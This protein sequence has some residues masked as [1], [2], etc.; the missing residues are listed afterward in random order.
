MPAWLPDTPECRGEL[1]Q[2][3]QAISRLDQGV[4]VL[5]DTLKE[6]GHWNDTL[7]LFLSDNG[8]PFPGAKTNLY[9][10]GSN[11]PLLV[12]DPS[13]PKTGG[14]TNARVTW[15]DVV[16]TILDYC[17]VKPK[18]AP[19]IKTQDNIGK[20]TARGKAVP[21]T[22]HGRSFLQILNKE[23]PKDWNEIY[24]SH[25]FHEITM[26]YP[27]RIIL[28]DQYKLTFNIAHDLPYPFASDLYASPTWQSVLKAKSLL[29]GKRTIYNYLHRPEFEMYDLKNDPDEVL[30]LAYKKEYQAEFKKLSEKLKAWQKETNDPWHLKW[31]Y[32]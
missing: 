20:R 8:P 6:T 19:A 29:Y 3:Y 28:S 22:T 31:E 5:L 15:A 17:E 4:G 21:F 11:L 16:P 7:I 1:A 26:Y 10:P 27:M 32:E 25:T 2:Y 23:N 24:L 9:Q 14:V 12:R 18:P 13:Q 30:N